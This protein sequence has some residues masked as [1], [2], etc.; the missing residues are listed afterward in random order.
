MNELMISNAVVVHLRFITSA[1]LK[2]NAP[3][4]EPFLDDGMTMDMFCNQFVEAMDR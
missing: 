4:Y 1:F 3:M 2:A